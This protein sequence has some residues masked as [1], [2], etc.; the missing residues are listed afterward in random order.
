M[1]KIFIFLILILLIIP[2]NIYADNVTM[3]SL[4]EIEASAG[5]NVTVILN[6]D[7]K[8][9]FSIL[10]A[11][12]HYD[13]S[14]LEYI[15]SEL[16]GLDA[17]LRGTDKNVDKG[18][19][20]M[21]AINL[22]D[23]KTMKDNGNIMI[24]E[25]KIKD[26]VTEDIPLTLEI[27]DFGK[28][29]NTKLEYTTKNGVIKIKNNVATVEKN[30]T[31][32]LMEEFN[33]AIKSSTKKEDTVTWSTSDSN[34]ASVDDNGLVIFKND[35]NVT[36]EAKDNDGNILYSKDYYVKEKV[37]KNYHIKEIIIGVIVVGFIVF[38]IFG[39]KKWLKRK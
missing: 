14:K 21:Y 22:S 5:N 37:N 6:M 23:D 19:V 7:N 4:N 11:R 3:F 30:K 17:M 31:Q 12:V 39:R 35:G 38:L 2:L 24:I 18:I 26:D 28:D 29:E 36:I 16:K 13:N 25:F 10:T 15:S 20:A 1:K 32:D 9:E 27:K 34:I 8:Q 33:E